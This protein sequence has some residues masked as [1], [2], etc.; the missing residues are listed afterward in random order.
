MKKNRICFVFVL[1]L[2]IG[3]SGCAK[4]VDPE[5]PLEQIRKEAGA[6]SV[7]QLESYAQLYASEIEEQ[8]AEIQKIQ[9]KIKKMPLDKMFSNNF[10][11]NDIKKIGRKAEALFE[12]YIIYME[13]LK[14]KGGDTSGARL[15][16]I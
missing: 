15:K 3:F 12:R 14:E 5:K 16:T 8:R 4:K 7:A 9:E 6:M 13:A 11:Q 1:A 2:T 10:L